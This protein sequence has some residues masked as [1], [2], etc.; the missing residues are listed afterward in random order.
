MGG[1]PVEEIRCQLCSKSIDLNTDLSDDENGKGVHEQCYVR[2]S[3]RPI[4]MPLGLQIS[5]LHEGSPN[6]PECERSTTRAA[7]THPTDPFTFRRGS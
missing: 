2:Q 4:L 5:D 1:H 6:D 3:R 7:R